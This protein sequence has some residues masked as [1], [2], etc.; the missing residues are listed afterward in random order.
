MKKGDV[1][2]YTGEYDNCHNKKYKITKT[3]NSLLGGAYWFDLE[4]L[5]RIISCHYLDILS[6]IKHDI[7]PIEK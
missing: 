4:S 6:V 5:D 3:Y 1:V 2:Y 7:K